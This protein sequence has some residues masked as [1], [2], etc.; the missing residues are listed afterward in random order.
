MA[1][2]AGSSHFTDEERYALQEQERGKRGEGGE[3]RGGLEGREGR[4]ERGGMRRGKRA[5]TARR[6]RERG[7]IE[8]RGEG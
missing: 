3:R 1:V 2:P 7:E 6:E 5:L 4:E 8:E